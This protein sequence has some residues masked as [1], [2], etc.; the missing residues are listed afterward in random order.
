[1]WCVALE[2][3]LSFVCVQSLCT[4]TAKER[5]ERLDWNVKHMHFHSFGNA[6]NCVMFLRMFLVE[7]PTYVTIIKQ[8]IIETLFIGRFIIEVDGLYIGHTICLVCAFSSL[9][10]YINTQACIAYIWLHICFRYSFNVMLTPFLDKFRYFSF[11]RI[12]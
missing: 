10:I 4:H 3:W 1:M 8:R 2:I 9:K 6:M 12:W 11:H 5:R 7:N